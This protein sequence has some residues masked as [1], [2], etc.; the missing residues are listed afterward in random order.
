MTAAGSRESLVAITKPRDCAA[1]LADADPSV[2]ADPLTGVVLVSCTTFAD[3]DTPCTAVDVTVATAT[4]P[5]RA[6]AELD[7][8]GNVVLFTAS[9]VAV[10]TNV[11]AARRRLTVRC[12][13][14]TWS[15]TVH[16]FM[17]VHTPTAASA[18]KLCR[19]VISARLTNGSTSTCSLV[20]CVISRVALC[21]SNSEANVACHSMRAAPS[22]AAVV[23]EPPRSRVSVMTVA[24]GGDGG[25][26]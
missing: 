22:A 9:T 13:R 1:E 25:G 14:E 2:D 7:A 4:A 18:S 8:L 16:A 12:R 5:A 21:C 26:A 6:V 11:A 24:Y 17:P 3:A 23:S 15:V 20:V 19:A 10:T